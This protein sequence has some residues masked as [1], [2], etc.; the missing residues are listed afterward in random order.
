MLFKSNY[1]I[2]IPANG[3]NKTKCIFKDTECCINNCKVCNYD[4][5]YFIYKKN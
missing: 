4:D 3:L 5:N 1:E 2:L